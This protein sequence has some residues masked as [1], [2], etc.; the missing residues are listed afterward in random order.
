MGVRVFSKIDSLV[1]PN[2][3]LLA[4]KC[5]KMYA[6][7]CNGDKISHYEYRAPQR[8]QMSKS[9]LSGLVETFPILRQIGNQPIKKTLT[10]ERDKKR[11]QL[12]Q[13]FEAARTAKNELEF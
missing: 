10:T 7:Y 12:T 13:E 6:E 2:C 11:K 8:Q 4:Q 5:A 3:T 9:S 1:W